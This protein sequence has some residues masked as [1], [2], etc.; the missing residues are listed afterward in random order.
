M[1]ANADTNRSLTRIALALVALLLAVACRTIWRSTF[2]SM[3]FSAARLIPK[4]RARKTLRVQ[5]LIAQAMGCCRKKGKGNGMYFA[6]A[7][8]RGFQTSTRASG[9]NLK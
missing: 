3:R 7:G 4:G 2:L 6:P 5:Y 1:R 8:R 9:A